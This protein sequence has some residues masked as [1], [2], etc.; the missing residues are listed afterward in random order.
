MMIPIK[1]CELVSL[2]LLISKNFPLLAR[3]S[4]SSLSFSFKIRLVANIYVSYWAWHLINTVFTGLMISDKF[5]SFLW[6]ILISC[7]Y[8]W[9]DLKRLFSHRITVNLYNLYLQEQ[10]VFSGLEK[11]KSYLNPFNSHVKFSIEC[12]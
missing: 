12:R 6:H 10:N 4:C 11:P 5:L 1:N 7:N 2:K 3:I 8:E 9:S